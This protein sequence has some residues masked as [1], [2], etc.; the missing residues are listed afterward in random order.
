MAL[1]EARVRNKN[2]EER[3][4]E[5]GWQDDCISFFAFGGGRERGRRSS[6]ARGTLMDADKEGMY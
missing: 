2:R 5:G 6:L 4:R 1:V 3:D